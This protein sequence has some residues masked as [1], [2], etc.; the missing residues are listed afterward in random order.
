MQGLRK[1]TMH[2]FEYVE[3]TSITEAVAILAR[4][5]DRARVL[6]GGTDV[7]TAL[8]EGWERPEW[9]ISLGR[10]PDL[11]TIRYDARD[12]LR[13]G[14]LATVRAVETAPVVRSHY[15]AL[16]GA[17][18][19][20]ASVQI[21]NLATVAG[22]LCR[23]APS[24]DMAPILVALQAEV[25]LVGPTGER[26]VA[27]GSFFIGPGRTALNR[28]E[29][30]T[31]IRVPPSS[32]GAGAAYIKHSPRRAMDLAVVG[33]AVVMTLDGPICHEARIV[34]GAVAPIPLRA[35]LAEQALIGQRA[36][37]ALAEAAGRIAASESQ[38][39]SD[40]RGSASYRRAMVALLTKRAVL[41]A[42]DA[43]AT[44]QPGNA[45]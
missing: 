41:Q 13:I 19:S 23:A 4:H 5:G 28:D 9:I 27:L 36:T 16:A 20:L 33:V 34:L 43:A 1:A 24:A 14:A 42:A 11:A 6:A 17:A 21:R 31:E 8:K 45:R 12:G 39:I 29:L 26:I 35:Q 30:L 18:G 38:P 40:V 7:L 22:N 37:S 3:P 2:P 32:L 10:I 25:K 15:P 44:T